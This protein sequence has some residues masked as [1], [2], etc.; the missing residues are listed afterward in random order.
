MKTEWL[1][2]KEYMYH[3]EDKVTNIQILMEAY[4]I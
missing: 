4:M 3:V 2:K 1:H